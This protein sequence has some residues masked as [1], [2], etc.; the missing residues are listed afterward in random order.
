MLYLY[1]VD[2]YITSLCNVTHTYISYMMSWK[3]RETPAV[4]CQK[5]QQTNAKLQ[6]VVY[7]EKSHTIH[8]WYSYLHLVD[9]CGKCR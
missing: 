5:T 9:C 6:V 7:Q 2:D 4:L 8:V 1:I 3:H